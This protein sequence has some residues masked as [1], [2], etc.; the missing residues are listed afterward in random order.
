MSYA[1]RNT[2][3]LA[4]VLLVLG[5][6]GWGWLN[7][8]YGESLERLDKDVEKKEIRLKQLG[9]VLADYDY[10]QD[11]LN[12]TLRKWDFYPKTLL[13]ENSVHETYRYLETI[14]SRRAGFDYEFKLSGISQSEDVIIA[15]YQLKGNGNY[16]NINRFIQFLEKSKPMYK[17]VS[18]QLTRSA[19]GQGSDNDIKV[20]LKFKGMFVSGDKEELIKDDDPFILSSSNFSTRYDPFRPSVLNKLPPNRENLL[21]VERA[22]VIAILKGLA[23]IQDQ[24]GNMLTMRVGDRIYLGLIEKIDLKKSEVIFAM[25]RG[26]IFDRVVLKL[27]N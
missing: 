24:G 4:A 26:G 14:S 10:M 5:G 9:V 7:F 20:T 8:T 6:L 15:N 17:I 23:Y 25:N 2:L 27:E 13:P 21:E 16:R 22:R 12:Q 1:L 11:K 19:G 3:V 18:L